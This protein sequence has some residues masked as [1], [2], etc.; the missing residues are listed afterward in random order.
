ML[1]G[2]SID[3]MN[4]DK[5]LNRFG[6]DEAALTGVLRSYANNTPPLIDSLNEYLA[7]GNM[8]DYA[9]VVH[10]VKGSS[11]GIFA[12]DTAKAAEALEAA[13]NLP[14]AAKPDPALLLELREACA[15]FD[16]DRVDAA[17]ERRAFFNPR[18]NTV[19]PYSCLP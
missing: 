3:G 10:G 19:R 11:Y 18:A 13:A 9:I 1:A 8:K 12:D 4:V 16:M 7:R 5:A 2:I 17:M 14:L 6:G 15:A